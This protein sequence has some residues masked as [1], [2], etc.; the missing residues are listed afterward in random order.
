MDKG[1]EDEYVAVRMNCFSPILVVVG[2]YG[3]QETSPR[4]KI[5][6]MWRRIFA[7]LDSYRDQGNRVIMTGDFNMWVGRCFGL[8]DNDPKV[9]TEVK[10]SSNW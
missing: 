1:A 9:S 5:R 6:E 3:R 10:N 7:I 8:K 2:L 4:E